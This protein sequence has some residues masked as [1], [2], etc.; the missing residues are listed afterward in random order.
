MT[1]RDN[2]YVWTTWVT[3][4][5][6]GEAHCE[7][8]AWFRAHHMYDKLP[9]DFNVARWTVDHTALV[10]EQTA[11]LR[12]D[13]YS[14]FIEEQN[15]FRLRG[16][17]GVTLA[18]K[19]DIV[20][21]H[22]NAVYVVDCKTGMPRHSDHIQVLVYMLILPYV[23]PAWKGKDL[24]GRVQYRDNLVEIPATAVDTEFRALF[25]RTMEQVGGNTALPRMPSHTECR[26]CDISRRDCPQ[27]IESPPLDIE[28]E[29]DLF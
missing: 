12:A 4:L 13:G 15:T 7:W 16:Q 19:P 17:Q 29:H 27:R 2:P 18:G 25:R 14:V 1:I 10:R 9:S 26:F 24:H 28:P 21:L 22:N 6:A 8:A 5:I 23:R 11:A 20:A 3:R